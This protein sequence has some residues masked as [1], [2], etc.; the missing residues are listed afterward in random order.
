MNSRTDYAWVRS[1]FNSKRI[2]LFNNEYYKVISLKSAKV[3]DGLCTGTLDDQKAEAK[4]EGFANIFTKRWE[5]PNPWSKSK[6]NP[7]QTSWLVSYK[8]GKI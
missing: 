5:I 1:I 7:G 6:E 3:K 2:E 8:R 4:L